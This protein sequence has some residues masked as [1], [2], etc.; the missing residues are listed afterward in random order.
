MNDKFNIDIFL[1]EIFIIIIKK[2]NIFKYHNLFQ[3]IE[4]DPLRHGPLAVIASILKHSA[5]EDVKPYSQLLLDNIL[6]L[7]ISDNPTDLIRKFGTKVV[8]RIGMRKSLNFI[9]M[10]HMYYLYYKN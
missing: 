1:E 10:I 2:S 6:K 8:Q 3:S 7:R 4:N 5:R 9:Y